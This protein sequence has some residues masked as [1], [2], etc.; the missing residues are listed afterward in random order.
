MSTSPLTPAPQQAVTIEPPAGPREVKVY[1]HSALFYWWPVWAVG[2]LMA[3]LTR[4]GPGGG[5]LMAIVPP[6][7]TA[8]ASATLTYPDPVKKDTQIN[9]GPRDV[10]IVEKDKHLPIN[11]ET[12]QLIQPTRHMSPNPKLGVFFTAVL[13]II[14]VITNIPLRGLWSLIVI[15]VIGLLVVI[16]ALAGWWEWIIEK[17]GL[18]DIHINE[19]GYV[20]ISL[21][22]LIIWILTVFVFDRRTY[23]VVSSGQVRVCM[24]VGA[25][26]TVYDTTGMTFSK[27]QDDLFRHWIIGLGSGDLLIHRSATHT[28]IDMPN[29]LFIGAKIREI[30][31]LIKE[32]EVV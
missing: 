5:Q 19:G 26:E 1:A 25:G 29:V 13:L 24:A 4:F 27:R 11:E 12:K 6:K 32:R 30:E 23:V 7:T 22:L 21:V 8:I 14:I 18:V 17:I 16:F 20:T 10:L 3:L 28:E 15:L 9:E 2:F 31:T